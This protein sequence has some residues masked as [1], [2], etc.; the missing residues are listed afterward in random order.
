MPTVMNGP[1]V[2]TQFKINV[3]PKPKGN[4]DPV[5]YDADLITE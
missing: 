2:P 4:T 5:V 1:K 3:Y